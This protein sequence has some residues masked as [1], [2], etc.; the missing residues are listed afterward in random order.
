MEALARASL[1]DDNKNG[2]IIIDKVYKQSKTIS[3]TNYKFYFNMLGID[4]KYI[5]KIN[6]LEHWINERQILI[7]H[8]PKSVI[9]CLIYTICILYDVNVK[10]TKIAAVCSTSTITINKCY[11]KILPYNDD[12]IK[13]LNNC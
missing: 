8:V 11:N 6:N 7:E 10:K 4:G 1:D 12:I 9:A 3:D 2:E 13:F 5:H